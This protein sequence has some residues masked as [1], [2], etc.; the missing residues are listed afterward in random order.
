MITI[1]EIHSLVDFGMCVV[2]WLVQLV[3]YPS[4]LR[5]EPSELPAWHKAYTFRVSFV[6]L[7]LML[8]Q[9]MLAILGLWGDPSILEWV[10]FAFV[11]VCWILTFFVS[12]PLHR[13]IEQNDTTKETRQKLITTNWPRTILWSLIFGLG[14]C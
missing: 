14:V 8:G 4:F 5:I 11:L 6:I 3:I 9:L 2:L 7:P 1:S 13:K 10:A 12:V